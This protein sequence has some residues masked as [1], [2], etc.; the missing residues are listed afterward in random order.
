MRHRPEAVHLRLEDPLRVIE[1]LG[2]AEE[3]H[4]RERRHC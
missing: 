2:D 3:A 4:E 1:R